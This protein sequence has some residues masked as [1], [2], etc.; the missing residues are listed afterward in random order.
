MVITTV[1]SRY[2][3]WR[4]IQTKNL[5]FLG[6]EPVLVDLA[7]SVGLRSE[8][9]AEVLTT[10][11][12]KAPVDADW[13]LS[14]EKAITAVP[15]FVMNQDKLVGAQPYEMLAKLVEAN[16]VKKRIEM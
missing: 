4:G 3:P 7:A 8:E 2:S 10:R 16:G 1:C 12:F 6:A 14:R 11:S 5:R 15:T 9:A 13:N